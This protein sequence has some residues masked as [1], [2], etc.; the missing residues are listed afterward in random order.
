MARD[1]DLKQQIG[2]D[3]YFDLVDHEKVRNFRIQKQ[4]PFSSFKV[5]CPQSSTQSHF[6]SCGS[7]VFLVTDL[8]IAFD[9]IVYLTFI[10]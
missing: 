2:K 9:L 10:E 7:F 6:Y 8:G 4:L 1:E 3:I 5:L